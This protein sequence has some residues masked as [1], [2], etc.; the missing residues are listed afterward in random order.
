MAV[1]KRI[2][3]FIATFLTPAWAYYPGDTVAYYSCS[4]KREFRFS[5]NSVLRRHY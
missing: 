3:S 4:D 5:R 2:N 1:L